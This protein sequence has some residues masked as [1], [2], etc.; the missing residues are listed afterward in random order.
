MICYINQIEACSKQAG[1]ASMVFAM[2]F[3][4]ALMRAIQVCHKIF[5][6][7]DVNKKF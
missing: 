5:K 4:N 6:F 2:S 7:K 3:K 1:E